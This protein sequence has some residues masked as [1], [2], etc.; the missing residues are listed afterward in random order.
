MSHHLLLVDI[1]L[2]AGL[3]GCCRHCGW[4]LKL[5]LEFGDRRCHLL[6]L[7]V[8][9]LDVVLKVYDR[10]RGLVQHLTSGV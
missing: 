8:L 3:S 2:C 10:V 9:L 5:L 7:E 1:R 6:E 4:H